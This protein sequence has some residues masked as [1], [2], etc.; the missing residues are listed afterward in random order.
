MQSGDISPALDEPVLPEFRGSL[1]L[2]N[3]AAKTTSDG[4][5]VIDLM[6]P[7]TEKEVKATSNNAIGSRQR[8]STSPGS[9]GKLLR[10]S[11]TSITLE[12]HQHQSFL[13]PW[14][15][16]FNILSSETLFSASP[17]TSGAITMAMAQGFF[18]SREAMLQRAVEDCKNILFPEEE[19][20]H[21][22]G[23]WLLTL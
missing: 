10:S 21:Y 14:E 16:S 19:D 3:S 17:S 7:S 5:D 22:L 1:S 11:W 15:L 4:L 8:S 9:S 23:S 20:G 13:T 12:M 2:A 18:S 6:T